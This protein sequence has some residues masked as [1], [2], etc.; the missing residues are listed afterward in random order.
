M[1]EFLRE[2][3]RLRDRK[4]SVNLRIDGGLFSEKGSGEK[5]RVDLGGC[6]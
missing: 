4:G 6:G 2:F 1:A 5:W 3:V